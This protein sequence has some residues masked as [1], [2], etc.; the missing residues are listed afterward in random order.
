[1]KK[2]VL[3]S[4]ILAVLGMTSSAM[5]SNSGTVN[6]TGS[7]STAT[8]DLSLKDSAGGDIANVDLGT[9]A[10]T[11]TGNGT[12]VSFKLIPQQAD[13]LTKTAATMVWSSPTLSATGMSNAATGG[14][15]ASMIMTASN[16]SATD[17]A[18][19]QGN[20]S[21]NYTATGGIKSFDYAA[22]LVKPATGTTMTAGVFSASASYTI[23]YK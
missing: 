23:A 10:S 22:Q 11:A 17:K 18:V 1:M 5:A 13:C 14:T 3:G 19:K 6:F 7:V 4:A 2:L 12:A 16:S 21:F 20:T 8:C 9:L 15:N